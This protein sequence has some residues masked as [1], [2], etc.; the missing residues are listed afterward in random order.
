M[1]SHY[2]GGT[3]EDTR[4]P[5]IDGIGTKVPR[6]LNQKHRNEKLETLGQT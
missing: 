5:G 1:L 6:T 4:M 3:V 2:E